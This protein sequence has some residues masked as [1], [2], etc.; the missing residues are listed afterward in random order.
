M[1]LAA[2]IGITLL[3]RVVQGAAAW[4]VLGM[5][6]RRLRPGRLLRRAGPDRPGRRSRRSSTCC[7]S[8]PSRGSTSWRCRRRSTSTGRRSRRTTREVI[9]EDGYFTFVENSIIV[10]GVSTLIALVLGVP[11]ALRLLAPALPRQRHVGVD[12]PQLPL[13]AAG[14]GRDP[15]LPDDPVPRPAGQLPRADPALRRLLAAARGLDH[16]RLLRRDPARDRRGGDGRRPDPAAACC[17]RCC[18]RSRG[19]ACSS[20]RRSA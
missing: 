13:H 10:T 4:S 9:H 19:R 8:R 5:T 6:A 3:F 17:S 7:S 15:D 11:A 12:D 20:P 1:V 18:C 16:D 2:A 14:R